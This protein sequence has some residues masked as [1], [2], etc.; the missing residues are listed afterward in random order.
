MPGNKKADAKPKDVKE[1]KEPKSKAKKTKGSVGFAYGGVLKTGAACIFSSSSPKP[2]EEFEALKDHYGKYISGRYVSCENQDTH[3]EK[4]QSKLEDCDQGGKN[5]YNSHSST[6]VTL[7]KEITG[8]KTAPKLGSKPAD[9]P[10]KAAAKKKA[11]SDSDSESE[12][13]SDS[14]GSD[15][16]ESEAPPP[17]PPKKGG[18]R[19][20]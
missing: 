11:E 1:T 3:F 4:L 19:K 20:K 18:S 17:P 6:L 5:V 15:S 16:S 8:E 12:A 14:D 10:K 13:G 9:K 7:I 2:E